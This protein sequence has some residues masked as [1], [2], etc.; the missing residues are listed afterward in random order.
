MHINI[1]ATGFELTSAIADYAEK[2]IAT[3]EK[4]LDKSNEDTVAEVEV[5]RDTQHKSGKIYKAEVHVTGGG[6]LDIYAVTQ[7]EDLYAAIDTV[8]DELINNITRSKGKQQTLAR[9][10]AAMMKDLMKGTWDTTAAAGRAAGRG[11]SWGVGK[12]KWRGF[13]KRP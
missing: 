10:S 4:Y 12:L 2:K 8:R 3:I 13:K 5:G 11:F 6:G 1:K 7:E 9:R